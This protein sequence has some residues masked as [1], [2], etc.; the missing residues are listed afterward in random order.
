MEIAIKPLFL[1]GNPETSPSPLP[2]GGRLSPCE[3]CV[4]IS[5]K[6]EKCHPKLVSASN[7][8]NELRDP[9]TSSG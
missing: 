5:G 2:A 7:G 4:A 6:G 3:D 1:G 9:E 8:T